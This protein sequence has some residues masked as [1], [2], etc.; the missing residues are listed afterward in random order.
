M[1]E[2]PERFTGLESKPLFI[3]AEIGTFTLEQFRQ[4][5][6]PSTLMPSVR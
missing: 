2:I 5:M 1:I 3:F 4:Y 6:N